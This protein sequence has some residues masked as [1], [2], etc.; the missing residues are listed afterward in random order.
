MFSKKIYEAYFDKWLSGVQSEIAF[1]YSI[2]STKGEACGK[3]G[4]LWQEVIS[5]ER[6][7][8]LDEDITSP[9][10]CFLDVG[11]GPFSR[12]GLKSEK[13]ALE[14]HAVDALAPAYKIMKNYF[15]IASGITPEFGFAE[16]V[17]DIYEEDSFDIVH[18]SNS[19]DHCVEPLIAIY[20]L[21]FVCKIGGKVI[22]RHAKN[23]AV[24][25]NYEGFH[26]WNLN[27]EN[28]DFIIW[29]DS[30]KFNITELLSGIAKIY[31][32]ENIV[33]LPFKR[34]IYDKVVIHKIVSCQIPDNF[35]RVVCIAKL[36]D[37]FF[38]QNL[39]Y[40]NNTEILRRCDAYEKKISLQE[41]IIR[42]LTRDIEKF[43]ND[44]K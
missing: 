1:W 41:K 4:E 33:E 17:G 29:N 21:L 30:N 20:N 18:M 10:T 16:L 22:L 25:E 9:V 42:R 3:G 31:V 44:L 37:A 39:L 19:L 6:P 2:I 7:F 24:R 12:C 43:Q 27:I 35:F 23:E 28:G 11:S 26:Q 38:E 15:G 13:T 8:V 32:Y 36:A 14:F 5:N 40:K 34:W